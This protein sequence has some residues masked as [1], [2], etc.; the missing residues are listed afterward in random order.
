MAL[1]ELTPKAMA[2]A[3]V[4]AMKARQLSVFD[5]N[6]TKW[7]ANVSPEKRFNPLVS[8]LSDKQ[9]AEMTSTP[10]NSFLFGYMCKHSRYTTGP[11]TQAEKHLIDQMLKAYDSLVG[12]VRNFGK[13][14]LTKKRK[15]AALDN[16][17]ASLKACMKAEISTASK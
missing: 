13:E 12:A 14:E 4:R 8:M 5:E 7:Y 3:T 17:V 6:P 11:K 15:N 1:I 16:F 9:R 2:E 10:E